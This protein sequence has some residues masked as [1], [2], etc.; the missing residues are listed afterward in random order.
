MRARTGLW[1]PRGG[2]APRPPGPKQF[3]IMRNIAPVG[4]TDACWRFALLHSVCRTELAGKNSRFY[5][6]EFFRFQKAANLL[7]PQ[8][9]ASVNIHNGL[10]LAKNQQ[11]FDQRLHTHYAEAELNTV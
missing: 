8:L 2:N 10:I 9:L 7:P 5:T 3:A 1:E 11:E 6:M 4:L